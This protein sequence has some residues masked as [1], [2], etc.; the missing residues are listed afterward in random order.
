LDSS[1]RILVVLLAGVLPAAGQVAIGAKAGVVSYR[2]RGRSE[3]MLNACAVLHLDVNSSMRVLSDRLDDARVELLSGSALVRVDE[4]V[5]Q[6]K[7][8]MVVKGVAVPLRT[9]GLYR[10][11]VDPPRLRVWSGKALSARA[12]RELALDGVSAAVKFNRERQDAL[13][14]W[15]ERRIVVLARQSGM[16][17]H[18]ARQRAEAEAA[19]KKNAQ[20]ENLSRD[21]VVDASTPRLPPPTVMPGPTGPRICTESAQ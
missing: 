3:A 18:L 20:L 13:D 17:A 2:E 5:R 4:V 21:P 12:G 16:A 6:T 1:I 15:S 9:R 19:A 14:R 11:D 10:F 8:T 7:I